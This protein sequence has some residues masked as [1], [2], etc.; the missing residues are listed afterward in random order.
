ME[1]RFITTKELA[2]QLGIK[3]STVYAWVNQRKISYIKIGRLVK[4]DVDEVKEWIRKHT[5][6]EYEDKQGF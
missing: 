2:E 3:M 4:F 6:K 1:K 5:I